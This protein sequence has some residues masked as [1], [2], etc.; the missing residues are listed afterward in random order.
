MKKIEERIEELENIEKIKKLKA[1]FCYLADEGFSGNA[2]KLDE[3]IKHFT[4][5]AWIDF[6]EFGRHEG[7]KAISEFLTQTVP[8]VI[9]FSAHMAMNPVIEVSGNTATGRWYIM[10]P[11]T[12]RGT[13]SPTWIQGKYNDEYRKIG[14]DWKFHSITT[15][16]DFNAPLEEG[17]AKKRVHK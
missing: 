5:D 15:T 3:L 12:N 14:E 7:K 1:S 8:Q 2:A 11:C 10:V 9:S 6:E 17:W 4:D 16:F 13:N